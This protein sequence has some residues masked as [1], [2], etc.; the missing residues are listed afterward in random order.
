MNF[1]CRLLFEYIF[2][3]A[4][5]TITIQ[6][7]LPRPPRGHCFFSNFNS[8]LNIF[9]HIYF[10]QRLMMPTDS[11]LSADVDEAEKIMRN[12]AVTN[13]NK[14]TMLQHLHV[15]RK[16]RREIILKGRNEKKQQFRDV[17]CLHTE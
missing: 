5:K 14:E 4:A 2:R 11:F 15:S 3:I 1:F 10:R 16:A 8:S 9:S 7:P 6:K 12:T 17:C 13:E